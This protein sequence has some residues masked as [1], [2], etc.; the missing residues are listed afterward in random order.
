MC[1]YMIYIL[2]GIN[3]ILFFCSETYSIIMAS[4]SC[5]ELYD[6][7]SSSSLKVDA[8]DDE[9][10]DERTVIGEVS[11]DT[12]L[13]SDVGGGTPHA[14][15]NRV[16]REGSLWNASSICELAWLKRAI[17]SSSESALSS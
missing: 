6:A 2:C 10:V 4:V 15:L 1:V 17:T 12:E 13:E 9:D 8:D 14:S 5:S 3:M 16:R 7:V 11:D